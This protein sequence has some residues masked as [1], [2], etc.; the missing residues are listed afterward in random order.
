MWRARVVRAA[1]F[2]WTVV[3]CLRA[4]P[5]SELKAEHRSEPLDILSDLPV[6]SADMFIWS[7]PDG[8]YRFGMQ[9]DDQWRVE[10]R[11]ADGSV[12]GHYYYKTPEGEVVD[13]SYA[14]GEQGYHARG[15]AI[16]GGA[17]PL[18][19]DGTPVKPPVLLKL[20]QEQLEEG[21]ASAYGALLLAGME[22]TLP[23]GNGVT[24]YSDDKN[25][26]IV[27]DVQLHLPEERPVAVFPIVTIPGSVEQV[28]GPPLVNE[29]P[30]LPAAILA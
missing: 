28:A 21:L 2:I 9:G 29:E 20:G 12:E 11:D 5:V 4:S 30:V 27:T 16:P 15:D 13:I 24:T 14:A 8:S 10:S 25:S 26:A 22:N 6:V 1:L 23:S 19:Q 7:S 17:A 18:Q 3:G